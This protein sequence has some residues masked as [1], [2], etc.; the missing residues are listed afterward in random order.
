MS[1]G[2]GGERGP[3]GRGADRACTASRGAW[4]RALG[5]A[6]LLVAAAGCATLD[7]WEDRRIEGEVKAR[8]VAERGANLTRLGVVSNRAVVYLSGT[9]Q[10]ADQKAR[11]EALAQGV[12]GVRRVVSVL[13]VRAAP[14]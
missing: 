1:R 10:S 6:V 13:E 3:A 2:E 9:V 12:N 5:A 14:K 8:L 7:P 11:A 4:R